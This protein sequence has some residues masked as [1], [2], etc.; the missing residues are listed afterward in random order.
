M[1]SD[2]DSFLRAIAPFGQDIV[3]AVEC[4]F[5]WYWLADLCGM[6]PEAYVNRKACARLEIYC[7]AV[8]T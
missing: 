4:I 8:C 2:P 1:K 7:D 3:V 6:I 5:I